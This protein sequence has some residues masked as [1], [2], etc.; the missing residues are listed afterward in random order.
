MAALNTSWCVEGGSRGYVPR[1][2]WWLF[3]PDDPFFLKSAC[4]HDMLL[5][6]GYRVAFADSQ[7]FE[8]ALSEHAPALRLRLAYSAMR[9]RRFWQWAL[10]KTPSYA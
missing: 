9:T 10:G 6:E 3:S 4:I 2:F 7:W 5:E 1:I 8:A